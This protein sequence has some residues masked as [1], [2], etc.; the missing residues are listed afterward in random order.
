MKDISKD[1]KNPINYIYKIK[2]GAIHTK[3]QEFV[4]VPW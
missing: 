1:P 2:D 4:K 3:N